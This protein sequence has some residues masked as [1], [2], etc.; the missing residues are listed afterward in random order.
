MLDHDQDKFKNSLINLLKSYSTINKVCFELIHGFHDA[1]RET[2]DQDYEIKPYFI[3]FIIQIIIIPVLII[4]ILIIN[5]MTSMSIQMLESYGLKR[6][7]NQIP[8]VLAVNPS[9]ENNYE[10][11]KILQSNNKIAW[12]LQ[13]FVNPLNSMGIVKGVKKLEDIKNDPKK[14]FNKMC[15]WIGIKNDP[16]LY[17]SEFMGKQFSR[18]SINFDNITGFDKKSIE[19]YRWEEYLEETYNL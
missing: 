10:I 12:A 4:T 11:I 6:E 5:L 7:L 3:I 8:E 16:T 1:Y 19:Y 14:T 17:K 2:N 9:F 13:Y 18:P 15:K